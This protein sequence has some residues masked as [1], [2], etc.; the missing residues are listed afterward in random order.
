MVWQLAVGTK[1]TN[2][3][4]KA[5]QVC[6]NRIEAVIFWNSLALLKGSH[7]NTCSSGDESTKSSK[8]GIEGGPKKEAQV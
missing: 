5:E 4:S 3:N 2:N 6:A 1:T 8:K 7:P